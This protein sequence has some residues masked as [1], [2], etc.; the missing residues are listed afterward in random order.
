MEKITTN[1][2]E[3]FNINKELLLLSNTIGNFHL[4]FNQ[5]EKIEPKKRYFIENCLKQEELDEFK[6]KSIRS[7]M[8]IL[9]GE[10]EN[11][12]TCYCLLGIDQD[13][14]YIGLDH[15][16]ELQTLRVIE[17]ICNELNAQFTV[18]EEKAGLKGKIIELVIEK[19]AVNPIKPEIKIGLFGEESSGKSTLIGVLVNGILDDGMGLARSNIF[20]YQ[21]ELDSGKTSNLSQYVSNKFIK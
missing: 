18:I 5:D 2:D 12:R 7:K 8:E 6:I 3:N 10:S 11:K 19:A 15:T 9:F 14:N 1:L 16:E 17:L 20:R 13:G 21:H 4:A